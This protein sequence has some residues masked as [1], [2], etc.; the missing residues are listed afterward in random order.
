[1]IKVFKKPECNYEGGVRIQHGAQIRGH[2]ILHL[3]LGRQEE[4]LNLSTVLHALII[5]SPDLQN[6]CITASLAN[7]SI[8]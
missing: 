5:S 7:N 3:K 6:I 2:Q 1:M 8:A 4:M